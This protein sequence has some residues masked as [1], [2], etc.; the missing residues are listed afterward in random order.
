MVPLSS[1]RDSGQRRDDAIV[2]IPLVILDRN[3]G[4]FGEGVPPVRKIHDGG[5][6]EP[7]CGEGAR[8]R[9]VDGASQLSPLSVDKHDDRTARVAWVEPPGL[10]VRV[11]EEEQP[12]AVRQ[13]GR[14][15]IG[16][17]ELREKGEGSSI[18]RRP[19]QGGWHIGRAT[20]PR[21]AKWKRVHAGPG[22]D[23]S[24]RRNGKPRE[25]VSVQYALTP[26]R[27][28]DVFDF[29][30]FEHDL[31]LSRLEFQLHEVFV[32]VKPDRRET[33][34]PSRLLAD[35]SKYEHSLANKSVRASASGR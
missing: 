27:L 22:R 14:A 17:V 29:V 8:G 35:S 30:R 34:V 7:A 21:C 6:R 16:E 19:N 23:D 31:N 15:C 3:A 11:V 9:W 25:G 18:S 5:E 28:R 26:E 13:P 12:A 20:E 2:R 1:V 24:N 4:L 32:W 10:L 33:Y